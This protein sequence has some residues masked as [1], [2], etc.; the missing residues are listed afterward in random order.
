[1]RLFLQ[2]E[3]AGRIASDRTRRIISPIGRLKMTKTATLQELQVLR[4][5]PSA[6]SGNTL[7]I[8]ELAEALRASDRATRIILGHL[9]RKKLIATDDPEFCERSNVCFRTEIG[10]RAASKHYR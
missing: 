9:H 5:I 2:I 10:D 3:K 4:N 7:A 1:M 6:N 8:P